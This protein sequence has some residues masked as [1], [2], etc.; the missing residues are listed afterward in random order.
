[1]TDYVQA[2]FGVFELCKGRPPVLYEGGKRLEY[3]EWGINA[4]DYTTAEVRQWAE[5]SSKWKFISE[6]EARKLLTPTQGG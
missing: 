6:Q 2:P 4:H 5:C 3:N 1:M